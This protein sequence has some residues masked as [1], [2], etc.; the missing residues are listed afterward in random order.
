MK[1]D[2]LV[3]QRLRA[4]PKEL[5]SERLGFQIRYLIYEYKYFP[6]FPLYENINPNGKWEI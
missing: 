3:G 4:P 1:N 2:P 5:N 6:Y